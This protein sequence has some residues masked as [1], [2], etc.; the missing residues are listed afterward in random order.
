MI[1]GVG[2]RF[3]GGGC[4]M[5]RF[6]A[7]VMLVGSILAFAVPDVPGQSVTRL[8]PT[9]LKKLNTPGDEEDPYLYVSRNGKIRRLFYAARQKD[10]FVLMVSEIKYGEWAP[11]EPVKGLDPASD[12]RSPCLTLDGHDLYCA[13]RTEFKGPKEED[14]VSL[15]YDLGHA[16]NREEPTQFTAPSPMQLLAT[17]ADEAFPWITPEGRQLYFSRKTDAGWRVFVATR[18]GRTGPFEEPTL[19]KELPAN[20]F[21]ATLTSD[22][23]TMFLQ[24]PLAK[25]RWGLFRSKRTRKGNTWTPWSSPPDA[26]Y[27]LNSTPEEAPTGDT[28]PSLSRDDNLLYFSSDRTGGKGGRDLWVIGAD[29]LISADLKSK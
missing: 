22:G 24:G 29:R 3:L 5:Y 19:I 26:L 20:F 9:P 13:V 1:A 6:I 14:T 4:R 28:S 16:I 7:V 10:R 2:N 27:F 8:K 15:N 21:H 11:G 23:R 18:Q 17:P 25:G 12:I